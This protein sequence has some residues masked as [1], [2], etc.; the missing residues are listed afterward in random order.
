MARHE[1]CSMSNCDGESGRNV[2]HTTQMVALLRGGGNIFFCILLVVRRSGS[3]TY[4]SIIDITILPMVDVL[5]VDTG[6]SKIP[7]VPGRHVYK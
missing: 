3:V 2:V 4:R 5:Q 6:V 1:T 7:D